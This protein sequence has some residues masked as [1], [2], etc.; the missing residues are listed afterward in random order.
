MYD[1]NE[2]ALISQTQDDNKKIGILLKNV[3]NI[4]K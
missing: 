2:K 1:N 3:K 4:S